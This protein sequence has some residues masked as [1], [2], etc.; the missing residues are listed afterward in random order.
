LDEL[1]NWLDDA[2][3]LDHASGAGDLLVV[4]V[5]RR[6][7]VSGTLTNYPNLSAYGARGEARLAYKRAFEDQLAVFTGRSSTG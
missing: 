2:D 6:L 5:L 7:S 4:T 3:W 1:S